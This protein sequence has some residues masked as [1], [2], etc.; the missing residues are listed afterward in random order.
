MLHLSG[1]DVQDIFL[2]MPN[3]GDMKDYRKAVNALNAYFAPKVDTMYAG[4]YFRQVTQAPGET[5]RQFATRL[6]RA[7][8]DCDYGEETGNQ[9]RDEFLC[10]CT[11]TY[12]KQKHLAEH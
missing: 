3:T 1:P 12:I 9:I 7:S 5:M 4:H 11:S 6:R 2:T 8:K 10:K